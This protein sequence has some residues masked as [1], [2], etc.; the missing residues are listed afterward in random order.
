MKTPAWGGSLAG[1]MARS[2][3]GAFIGFARLTGAFLGVVIFAGFPSGC[4][5]QRVAVDAVADSF[6]QLGYVYATDEDPELVKAA[7]PFGLKTLEALLQESPRH[8]ELLLAAASGFTQ[9]AYA[10]VQ[11]EAD[12]VEAEDL[13]RATHL[14]ERALRLYLRAREYGMRGLEVS[15]P[16]LR[17]ALRKDPA[18]A[19]GSLTRE[20]VPLLFWTAAA[21]GSAISL[22]KNDPELTADISEVGALLGRALELDEAYEGGVIHELLI[23]YDGGRPAAAG[24]SEERAR[25]HL[26]AAMRLSRGTR[27]APLVTF[28]ETVSVGTQNRQEFLSL[29]ND[30]LAIDPNRFPEQRL[31]NEISQRRAR[32]LLDHTD[33]LFLE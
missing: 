26:E 33:E 29:L 30:A 24:G 31:A 16:G 27:A 21:W 4:S 20:D 14:R 5:V 28:A 22:A 32:W 18:Q 19:L 6:S 13:A 25:G 10:F 1:G 17:V 15:R 12:V 11:S 23:A 2:R 3:G 8:R 7:A 9:Y